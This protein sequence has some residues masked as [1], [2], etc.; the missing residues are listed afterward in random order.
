M[1]AKR[2]ARA[3]DLR[4]ALVLTVVGSTSISAQ[5]VHHV[6]PGESI[7]AAIDAAE[8]GDTILVSP[9]TYEE[10]IDY[11]GKEIAILGSGWRKTFLE[12]DL[13]ESTVIVRSGQS[14]ATRIQGF[15]IRAAF[16]LGAGG[17]IHAQGASP[18]V[19]DCQIY[20]AYADQGGG[21]IFGDPI[22]DRCAFLNNLA[23]PLGSGGAIHGA[24]TITRCLFFGNGVL[25]GVEGGALAMTGGSVTDS[26]FVNNS[27]SNTG[28]SAISVGL[29]K[30]ALL[31]RCV[32]VANHSD[33][34]CTVSGSARIVN[35][36]I[37]GNTADVCFG[38]PV[39]IG[40]VCGATSIENSIVRENDGE[41]LSA[42]GTVS[43]S[44][45]EGGAIGIGNFDLDALFV[46]PSWSIYPHES[47][48]HLQ[49]GS[50][51]IDAG[52]P[53]LLDPDG[54]PLDV[55]AHYF[56]TLY[57]KD[58]EGP[59]PILSWNEISLRMGGEQI[60]GLLPGAEHAGRSYVM[61][62][63]MS[64]TSPGFFVQGFHVPLNPDPYLVFTYTRPTAPFF[65]GFIGELDALG[66]ATAQVRFPASDLSVSGLTLHHA[67]GAFDDSGALVFVSNAEALSLMP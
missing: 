31:D 6:H 20:G 47:D 62:G 66:R 42:V 67:Y 33:C 11:Q 61:L 22:V 4:A 53:A 16:F 39:V 43:Y 3:R 8:N 21:G 55:G 30:N 7:Q 1:S 13:S 46:D 18:S 2:L 65:V 40:G 59:L 48:V 9:G 38:S 45:V 57:T 58:S 50:P 32:I 23:G 51:C 28:G 64:G 10:N 5:T 25:D 24:P 63:S 15:T 27:T 14:P 26:V 12:G 17:G 36:T 19:V 34:G 44:N 41:E 54:T 56:Q 60:L 37:V 49:Q 35:C 52:D 29:G